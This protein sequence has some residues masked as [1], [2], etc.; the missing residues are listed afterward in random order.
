MSMWVSCYTHDSNATKQ[1]MHYQAMFAWSSLRALAS[2]SSGTSQLPCVLT[3]Y[4]LPAERAEVERS[5]HLG[6]QRQH[7]A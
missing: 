4:M 1:G 2:A 7:C 6:Q 5:H 3:V